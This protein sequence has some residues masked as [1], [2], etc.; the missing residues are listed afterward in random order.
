MFRVMVRAHYTDGTTIE[1]KLLR[2]TKEMV[3]E[4]LST[5][6][7]RL[8]SAHMSPYP[9]PLM[10]NSPLP[11]AMYLELTIRILNFETPGYARLR[12]GFPQSDAVKKMKKEIKQERE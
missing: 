2:T 7:F 8:V 10:Q 1:S 12:P 6:N 11:H 9:A 4:M 5:C 3:T